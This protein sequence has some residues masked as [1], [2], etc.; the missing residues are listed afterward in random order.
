MPIFNP[1]VLA[2]A[3]AA[4]AALVLSGCGSEVDKCV[5][6]IMKANKTDSDRA[7]LEARARVHCMRA[8]AG[9]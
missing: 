5:D 4:G 9:N 6:S 8:Q 1:V 2:A 7:D 3:V